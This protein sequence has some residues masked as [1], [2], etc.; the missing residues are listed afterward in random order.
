MK[1]SERHRN[2]TPKVIVRGRV[3]NER[4]PQRDNVVRA[5]LN[6][7]LK[8]A[9]GFL[10]ENHRVAEGAFLR[11][12]PRHGVVLKHS[13]AA[14][15]TIQGVLAER[16]SLDIDRKRHLQWTGCGRCGQWSGR[17]WRVSRR[18]GWGRIWLCVGWFGS[19]RVLRIASTHQANEHNRHCELVAKPTVHRFGLL[20]RS[21]IWRLK[22]G[23]FFSSYH[24]PLRSWL[25][26]HLVICNVRLGRRNLTPL[27]YVLQALIP[28]SSATFSISNYDLTERNIESPTHSSVGANRNFCE[29]SFL[30]LQ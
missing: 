24:L 1:L 12:V 19:G 18:S 26:S 4:R 25:T 11:V 9:G 8:P 30:W 16:P 6:I 21:L 10:K 20:C 22:S 2:R 28:G 13:D 14:H 7:E 5:G 15:R 23:V 29:C 17:S 3:R 27:L